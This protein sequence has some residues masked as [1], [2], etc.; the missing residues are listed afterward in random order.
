MIFRSPN[1][2][3]SQNRVIAGHGRI[4]AA[5]QLGIDTVPVLPIEHLTEAQIRAYVIADNKLAENANWNRELLALE[6]QGLL[7]MELDF[8]ITLT[9][10]ET[11]EIDVLIEEIGEDL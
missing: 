1:T 9:G 7:D 3:A 5:K 4:E 2:S 11:A 6:L 8:D 10:F